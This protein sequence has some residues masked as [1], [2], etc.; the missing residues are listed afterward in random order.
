M[1]F[2]L[3]NTPVELLKFFVEII[4]IRG[5]L[6]RKMGIWIDEKFLTPFSGWIKI[7][8]VTTEREAAI[9]MHYQNKALRKGHS[10]VNPQSCKDGRC[11]LI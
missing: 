7:R 8:L 3:P 11:I 10:H 6:S 9:W 2:D 4:L 5:I 1:I